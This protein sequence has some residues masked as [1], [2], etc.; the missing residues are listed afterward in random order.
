MTRN[1]ATATIELR[2]LRAALPFRGYDPARP[3]LAGLWIEPHP[4][5]TGVLIVATDRVHMAVIH[6]RRGECSH[7]AWWE[8][9]RI[10]E[11]LATDPPAGTETVHLGG[12]IAPSTMQ[13]SGPNPQKWRRVIPPIPETPIPVQPA[14][15]ARHIEPF[16]VAARV[17]DANRQ[18]SIII[19]PTEG[20][21]PAI[22]RVAQR[23]EFLGLLMPLNPRDLPDGSRDAMRVWR[24][25]F[26][27]IG[28]ERDR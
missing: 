17:L 27:T 26:V 4:R 9:Q 3:E 19:T 23:P 22:V 6:D 2:Y 15:E 7:A 24:E 18:P 25:G 10:A 8:V 16:L 5:D 21:S 20:K 13:A 12:V 14:F 1:D 11:R 28:K